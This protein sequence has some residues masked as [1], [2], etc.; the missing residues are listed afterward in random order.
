MH[1]EKGTGTFRNV[2]LSEFLQ[3]ENTHV[4]STQQETEHTR[5]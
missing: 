2:Y 4:A 5:P 3:T 1:I